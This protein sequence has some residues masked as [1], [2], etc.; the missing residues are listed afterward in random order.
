[1]VP[2]SPTANTSF[3][4]AAHTPCSRAVVGDVSWH[5]VGQLTAATDSDS[6][7]PSA[8]SSAVTQLVRSTRKRY[9]IVL[10]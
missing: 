9:F 6:S 5:Q 7:G 4:L 10:L 1:M 8:S 3:A 2:L